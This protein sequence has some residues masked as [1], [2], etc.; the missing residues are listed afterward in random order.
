[1]LSRTEAAMWD[2]Q[3]DTPSLLGPARGSGSCT[4]SDPEPLEIVE[5]GPQALVTVDEESSGLTR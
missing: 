2:G 1:M 3:C 5:T 4:R